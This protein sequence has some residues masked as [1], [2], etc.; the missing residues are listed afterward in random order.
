MSR[1][2][3]DWI[4]AVRL[5]YLPASIIPAF[6]GIAAA[7]HSTRLINPLY[8]TFT[9]LGVA[10]AHMSADLFNDYYDFKHG[11]DQLSASRGLSGGSGVLVDGVLTERQVFAGAVS[12][13]A[14]ASS[15]GVYL[16]LTRGLVVLFLLLFGAITIVAYTSLLQRKGVGEITLALERILTVVGSY[17]VQTLSFSTTPFLA[18]LALGFVS[19]F[20]VYYAAFPDYEADSSTGKRTLVTI[21]GE[22]KARRAA[23]LLPAA[24]YV[25]TVAS[26]TLGLLP[27]YSLSTLLV[28]PL[29]YVSLRELRNVRDYSLGLQKGLKYN[30]LYARLFGVLLTVSFI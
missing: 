8:A 19:V 14:A 17:Y 27:V 1:Y 3:S 18:G 23:F 2:T 16:A 12:L 11:T 13:L 22:A 10:F 7:W 25:L 30:S 6:T 26:V 21:L 24:A 20:V 5:P 15:F 29:V 4:R 9:I 28:L